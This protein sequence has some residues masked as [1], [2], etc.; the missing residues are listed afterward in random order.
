[1]IHC[2]Q[3]SSHVSIEFKF[4]DILYI[5]KLIHTERERERERERQRDRKS[6]V[7][8]LPH[9]PP[10]QHSPWK[11]AAV[12]R[13]LSI[14]QGSVLL[15]TCCFADM[16]VKNPWLNCCQTGPTKPFWPYQLTKGAFK[17]NVSE[18]NM[19]SMSMRW[20]S[21][22]IQITNEQN[23]TTTPKWNLTREANNYCFAR[24]FSMFHP[25]PLNFS[26]ETKRHW[27][28]QLTP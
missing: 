24:W 10:H 14:Q 1:M 12:G 19:Y 18:K 7:C 21:P 16:R 4:V 26:V 5:L 17:Q 27:F 2:A 15:R 13:Q 6:P 9:T 23:K 22:G 8:T 3:D 20:I 11:I 28:F 25:W